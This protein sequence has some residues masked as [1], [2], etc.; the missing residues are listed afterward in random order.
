MLDS[1]IANSRRRESLLF[2]LAVAFLL[3][4]AVALSL[5]RSARANIWVFGIQDLGF[6]ISILVWLIC[7]GASTLI[8]RRALP[9]HD[10]YLLPLVYL[11]TGWGLALIWR[12]TPGFGLRQT[13]WMIVATVAML[14]LALL[15]GDL[16]WLRRYRYTW[17]MAGLALTALTLLFG[18]NPSGFGERLWLGCC[19]LYLQ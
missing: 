5:T 12:L 1:P 9:D 13:A 15:P 7:A 6:A 11:L 8:V 17:L 4:V 18:V 2:G 19:G 14:G 3:L 10:P 16:R